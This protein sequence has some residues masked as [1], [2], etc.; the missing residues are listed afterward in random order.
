MTTH[1]S[2]T[3]N[4]RAPVVRSRGVTIALWVLQAVTAAALLAAGLSAL[5]GADRSMAVF[6]AIGLGEWLRYLTG[7]LQVAGAIGLLI[8]RLAGLAG[9][10]FVGMW[11][12]ALAV[13]VFG[14]GGATI[15][16]AVLLVLNA[17]IAWGRR[18]ETA[19]LIGVGSGRA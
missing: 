1:V 5:F 2:H 19:A 15:P 16:A 8:P 17:I 11:L 9:L 3:T 13:H 12:V 4:R 10:A 14:I 6:Q 18:Q 7:A